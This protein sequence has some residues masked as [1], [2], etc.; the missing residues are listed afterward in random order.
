MR[1]IKF[2]GKTEQGKWRC[3]SLL[4]DDYC[5]YSN[6]YIVE[7][8]APHEQWHDVEPETIGQF[9]GL[10]DCYGR[11]I[12]E[13][14]RLFIRKNGRAYTADVEWNNELGGFGL[15]FGLGEGINP[16]PLGEWLKEYKCNVLGYES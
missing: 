6:C 9:T 16:K 7:F 10:L 15:N 4:Q 13:G 5:N 8:V 12:Y 11:E 1:T 3:G 2:R 14:D